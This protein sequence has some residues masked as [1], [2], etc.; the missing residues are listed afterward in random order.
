[1]ADKP[2]YEDLE[3][4]NEL[5]GQLLERCENSL[6]ATRAKEKRFALTLAATGDGIWDWDIPTGKAYFSPNYYKMLGY[7]IN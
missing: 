7:E 1:M 5:L 4:R 2:S 3:K 6:N